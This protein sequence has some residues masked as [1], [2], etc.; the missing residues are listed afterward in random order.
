MKF[1]LG[2]AGALLATAFATPAFAT[3][4]QIVGFGDSLSDNGNLYALVGSPGAPY[5]NGRFSNGPVALERMSAQMGLGLTDFAYGGAQTG[6]GNLAGSGLYGTGIA[7]QVGMYTALTGGH[8]DANALYFVWGG[9]NDFFAGSNMFNPNTAPTAANNIMGDLQALYD[10]GARDFF[11]PLMPNLGVTPSANAA[12]LQFPGYAAI[13]AQQSMY[14]DALLSA[15]LQ[16]F[17][18]THAGVDMKIFDTASFMAT[19]APIL[20]GQGVNITDSC[21]V[22]SAPSL[23]AD[24]SKYLFWDGVHPTS[25]G[26]QLLA[27]AFVTA[28]IP[29]PETLALMLAGLVVV[30]AKARRRQ[31]TA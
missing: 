9:P 5:W 11:V 23:C 12:N 25:V 2:L 8:A 3:Y 24:P 6:M 30:G 18:A 4:S 26:H 17:G 29:E 27:D 20:A 7:G 28:A 16:Q 1:K 14:Y 15:D 10:I 19:E 22:A 31:A 13:A 21:F